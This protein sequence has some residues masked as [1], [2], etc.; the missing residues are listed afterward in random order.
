[1]ALFWVFVWNFCDR[2]LKYKFEKGAPGSVECAALGL[3]VMSLSPAV[4][5]RDN[6]KFEEIHIIQIKYN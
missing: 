5:C 4:E 3:K 1:M 6:L 2:S